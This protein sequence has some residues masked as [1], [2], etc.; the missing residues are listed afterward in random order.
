[1]LGGSLEPHSTIHLVRVCARARAVVHVCLRAAAWVVE[2]LYQ[3]QD[4]HVHH[5]GNT[6]YVGACLSRERL[7]PNRPS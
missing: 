7:A 4:S 1:M 3:K 5:S 6:L 2:F